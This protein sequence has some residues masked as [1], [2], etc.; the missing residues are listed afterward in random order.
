VQIFHSLDDVL[1]Q[2]LSLSPMDMDVGDDMILGWD[3]ISSYDL[4]HLYVDG[5]VSL[6]SGAS[7]LLQLDLLSAS[8]RP[9]GRLL[10]VIV[11]SEFRR[12]LLPNRAGGPCSLCI[13]AA[14]P[15]AYATAD[16]Q[17][18]DG[19]VTTRLRRAR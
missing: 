5:Q 18:L 17:P 12:L 14:E 9:A 10:P 8:A 19:M 13:V 1:S 15:A 6:R 7:V 3:W 2:S 4:R 11:H 16:T